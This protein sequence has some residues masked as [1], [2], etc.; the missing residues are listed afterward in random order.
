VLAAFAHYEWPGNV[1]ELA[2]IVERL[3]ILHPGTAVTAAQVRRLLPDG[4]TTPVSTA[5]IAPTADSPAAVP[6]AA[7]PDPRPD[8]DV[9]SMSLSE[10]LEAYER[11]LIAEALAAGGGSV[12][13]AARRLQT[14]RPNLYRR[15]RRLGLVVPAD[16]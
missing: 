3:S 1:R 14:D 8:H 15:M 7:V 6:P 5:A 12:A 10:A 13:E 9:P 4:M 11:R 16:E 2:N